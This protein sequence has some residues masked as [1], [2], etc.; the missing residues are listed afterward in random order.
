MLHQSSVNLLSAKYMYKYY[1]TW[2]GTWEQLRR[3]IWN[4]HID[5]LRCID[6]VS[7]WNFSVKNF[8]RA[9]ALAVYYHTQNDSCETLNA[10]GSLS[11]PSLTLGLVIVGFW[12]TV[13]CQMTEE[14]SCMYSHYP[15][16]T[17]PIV[18]FLFT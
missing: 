5:Q 3:K 12:N 15:K 16:C 18:V 10:S 6:F 9:L 13:V 8:P 17:T 14:D 2:R 7:A 11:P 1:S 4:F